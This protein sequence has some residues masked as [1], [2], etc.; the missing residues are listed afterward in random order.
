M[1]LDIEFDI[2]LGED[3]IQA[4]ICDTTC[5][6]DP[7]LPANCCDGYGSPG[8]PVKNDVITTKLHWEY[9][10]GTCILGTDIGFVPGTQPC[11]S[12]EFTA[13][14][15]GGVMVVIG[16][17]VLSIIG[18]FPGTLNDLAAAV[19]TDINNKPGWNASYVGAV[20]T[21][22][23]DEV[24][25][26]Y[27]GLPVQIFPDS[28][29]DIAFTLTGPLLEGGI[30]SD[31][32]TFTSNDLA[33]DDCLEAPPFMDGVHTV[34][35]IVCDGSGNE[36]ARKTRKF[37]FDCQTKNCIKELV[38]LSVDEKCTCDTDKLSE[39]IAQLRARFEA[40]H[41]QMDECL[42]DCANETIQATCK[43]CLNACL[44]C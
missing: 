35:Y 34:T 33:N 44:D 25:T 1:P 8:N 40:A 18:T 16:T 6:F 36:L 11:Q 30:G 32:M 39:K 5:S 7:Q 17:E 41:I 10:D 26:V 43:A 23:K 42:F 28:G 9:P 29:S 4:Q 22:C 19:A 31:C 15:T 20:V 13:G 27:N 2:C 24:G 12:F 21:V 3:C 37:L 38:K 14:T